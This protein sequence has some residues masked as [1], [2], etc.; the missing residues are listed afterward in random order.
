M[1]LKVVD[2]CS[3][4]MKNEEKNYK[5]KVHVHN[6]L[7]KKKIIITH[8]HERTEDIREEEFSRRENY[9]RTLMLI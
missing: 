7:W 2:K 3:N 8:K 9:L 1:T 6:L 4:K 5:A